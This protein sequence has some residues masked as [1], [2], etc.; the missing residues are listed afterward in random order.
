M[1]QQ[2]GIAP[3]RVVIENVRPSVDGGRFPAK[4]VTGESVQVTADVFCDGHD[5]VSALL[6]Y[7][8]ESHREWTEKP[9]EELGNDSWSA[10]FTVQQAQTYLFTVLA[11]VD[12]FKTWRRDFRKR[13]DA[14]QDVAVDLLV[15]VRLIENAAATASGEYA[16]ELREWAE[17]LKSDVPLTRRVRRVF[18]ER[19]F[20]IADQYADRSRS[21]RYDQ[22]LRIWVDREKARFSSW[23]EM[24]PRSCSSEGQSHGT[25]REC[26]RCIDYVASMGF[27]VL[28]L[29]PIHPVGIT[30]RKG[31][32]NSTSAHPDDPGS[33]WAIGAP[34]GGHKEIN[35][36]L[37]T[38]DDF[39][40]L[41][42][43]AEERGIELAMDIAFQ[44][45]PDHPY[46]KDHPSWFKHRPDGTIQFAENPPK[47][48]EDIYPFDFENED[49]QGLWN[50]LRSVFF[51]WL[52][53]GIRIFRID[54]P[55]TKPFAFW[56]WVIAEVRN[57]YPDT[58]FLSEAFTRPKV[59]YRLAKIGFTQSYTY[60][61]WRNTKQ[62][63]IEYMTELTRTDVREFFRP[64]FWPNTPDILPESLHH[65]GRSA[66]ASRLVLA[67]TLDSNY[68][69]YGPAYELL[70]N[71][72]IAPGKEEYLNSEKYE[73]KR[74]D[75]N[76]SDSLKDLIARV[77]RIRLENPALQTNRTLRFHDID[78]P[79]M[80][81]YSKTSEDGTG[82]IVTV[83]NL[84]PYQP[85]SGWL[86]LD[87][88]ALK[89]DPRQPFLAHD[90]LGDARFLWHGP[91]NLISL[92]PQA[93]PAQVFAI[94]RRLRTE[95]D[96]DYYM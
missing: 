57:E 14:G 11:W 94:H 63:L 24:F 23:Y 2:S 17:Y 38:L 32:N 66:F 78:N 3:S 41:K 42:R 26:E 69:I 8:P 60:F 39:L 79:E 43:K 12:E 31:K 15:G 61:T 29:P 84:D 52:D 89:I 36:D 68:G 49:W 62:E 7:R 91:R 25:F 95:R 75:R 76:R 33:P 28:Y 80:I 67:A 9:M 18:D 70:E 59:M 1:T 58:I 55:H 92:D 54:N 19:L 16:A 72:P 22:E 37:G 86:S 48:Y 87:L 83:V 34:Q 4:R 47:R 96:F 77:N 21:T 20:A 13:V 71:T 45:T 90:L 6:L 82:I 30:K 81:A 85:R 50:E 56:Q 88:D 5:L 74:W 27:D 73:V 40:A 64:N 51:F 93:A 65:A 53:K 46:V 35:P 10:I 44:A